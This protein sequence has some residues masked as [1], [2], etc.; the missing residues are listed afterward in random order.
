MGARAPQGGEKIGRH[1][2]GK[3]QVHPRQ[4]VHPRGRVRLQFLRKWGD[5]DDG[6]GY[7][8]SFSPCFEGH[9]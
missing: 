9:D 8:G 3:W 4:S 7:L 5:R 1:L 2:Q 6:S